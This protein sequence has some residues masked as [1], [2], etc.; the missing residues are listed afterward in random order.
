MKGVS[1][2]TAALIAHDMIKISLKFGDLDATDF[3]KRTIPGTN[4]KRYVDR[5]METAVKA[6]WDLIKL[7]EELRPEN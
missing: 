1:P 3:S 6:A 4:G 7:A 2:G 5:T